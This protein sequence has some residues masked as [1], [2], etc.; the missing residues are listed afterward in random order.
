MDNNIEFSL[1]ETIDVLAERISLWSGNKDMY[2]MPEY[3]VH[4]HLDII[5]EILQSDTNVP[6]VHDLKI[7]QIVTKQLALPKGNKKNLYL[8]Q[9]VLNAY[10]NRKE[11]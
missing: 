3:M 10:K 2:V 6:S 8:L 4:D 1:I 11:S 9:Q 7:I 5:I